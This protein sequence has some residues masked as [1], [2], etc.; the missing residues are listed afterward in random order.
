MFDFSS[1]LHFDNAMMGGPVGWLGKI[2]VGK[3]K[4]PASTTLLIAGDTSESLRDTVD[5]LNAA[6]EHYERVIAVLGN[7]EKA[8]GD[9]VLRENVH[10]LDLCG[11]EYRMDGI[12]YL[13][14]C[15][16]DG[17]AVEVVAR[18]LTAAQTDDEVSRVIV[19]SHF[20]PTPRLCDLVG[21]DFRGKCNGLLDKVAPPLKDTTIVFGHVHLPFDLILDGYRLLADPRGYKGIRRDGTAWQ[22]KFASFL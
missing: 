3:Y 14:G 5:F 16:E 7:H 21:R 19:L 12:A 10:V 9:A 13:G 17:A 18:K 6:A 15:L 1:D 4:N 8:E 20:A 2:D 11:Y 22:G